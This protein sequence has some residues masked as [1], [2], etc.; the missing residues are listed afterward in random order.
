MLERFKKFVSENTGFLIRLDDIAENMNWHLMERSEVLFDKFKVKPILGVIPLNQD[1][2]L[3]SYPKKENFW[4]LVRNWKKKGWNISMHGL[5]HVYDIDTHKKDYFKYGGKSEFFGHSLDK[6][7]ERIKK[8]L[9]K[10]REEQ[11]EVK[12]FFAPNHT[13]DEKTFFALKNSGIDEVIDGYG[14]MPY[15]ENNIKFIP[16]LFYKLIPLP[17]GIQTFQ[18]HLNYLDNNSFKA[19]E[20]FIENNSHKIITYEQAISK[21]K[22]NLSYKLL[23]IFTEKSLKII[24]YGRK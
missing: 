23:R 16:Q 1:E 17:F 2:E 13:Y 9:N 18:I 12:S 15:E 6:Q 5:S 4:D 24:R 20:K 14:L 19:F 3:L 10:F 22:K 8:G 7:T 21:V 11:I